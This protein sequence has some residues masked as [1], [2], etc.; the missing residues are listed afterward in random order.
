MLGQQVPGRTDT[1]HLVS[2]KANRLCR[3]KSSAGVNSAKTK[4]MNQGMLAP[5]TSS[6]EF[7]AAKMTAARFILTPFLSGVFHYREMTR[8]EDF[9]ASRLEGA[10]TVRKANRLR[11]IEITG[12]LKI[13]V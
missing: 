7:P 13:V 9:F 6:R 10:T 4:P 8:R 2:A 5:P 3:Q 12:S 1:V 11:D